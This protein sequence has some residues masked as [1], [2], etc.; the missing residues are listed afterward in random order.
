M[1]R[2][3]NDLHQGHE[4]TTRGLFLCW[5]VNPSGNI[6]TRTD[7]VR[8]FHQLFRDR[9]PRVQPLLGGAEKSTCRGDL[10]VKKNFETQS[11]IRERGGRKVKKTI[12]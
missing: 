7:L 5:V 4:L 6:Q 11:N 9:N 12:L 2:G 1:K 3:L 8:R 10:V